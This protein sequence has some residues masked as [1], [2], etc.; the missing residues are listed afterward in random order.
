[1][2]FNSGLFFFGL[3]LITISLFKMLFDHEFGIYEITFI[4]GIILS[5]LS[6]RT[7][8]EDKKHKINMEALSKSFQ[9]L[10]NAL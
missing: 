10:N 4:I 7:P 9:S 3:G 2:T 1:M 8:I 5:G 6:Y